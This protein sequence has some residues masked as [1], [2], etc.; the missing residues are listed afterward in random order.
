MKKVEFGIL[1]LFLFLIIFCPFFLNQVRVRLMTEVIYFGLF[2]VSLNLIL[3]YGGLLSFGHS[4][5]FGLGA[6]V[7]ALALLHIKGLDL[8]SVVLLGGLAAALVGSF[9]SLFLIRVSGTYFAMLTMAFGQLLYAVALKWR[10]VTRGDDGIGNFPRPDLHIPLLGRVDMM[11]ASNFYWFT[12][13]IVGAMVFFA[14]YI[15]TRTSL[16]ISIILLREN[17][18]RARFLGHRTS[19][20]RFW[21]FTFSSFLAGISGSLFGIFQ[22]LV[23]ATS[24]DILRS[25][26]PILMVVI[27]GM[28]H[29]WGPLL[30]TLVYVVAGDWLS[31]ITVRWEFIIGCFFIVLV[32]FLRGGLISLIL[33]LENRF[34]KIIGVNA[35]EPLP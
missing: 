21:L 2:A 23:T 32:L 19:L 4:A 28:G 18:E 9:F 14:W 25:T 1:V 5:Y 22:E 20:T 26:D 13:A 16:G 31:G 11:D 29:F 10:S 17:E 6:Y 33:D 7:T 8:I 24:I 12:L 27:G 3:G 35:K 34:M 30:G 15:I